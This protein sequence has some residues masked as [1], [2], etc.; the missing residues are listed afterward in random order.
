[1]ESS[2]TLWIV[3]AGIV[4]GILQ[5]VIYHFVGG[6]WLGFLLAGLCILLGGIAVHAI[7]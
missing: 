6:G 7:T 4:V 3:L 5:F 2:K 1:M